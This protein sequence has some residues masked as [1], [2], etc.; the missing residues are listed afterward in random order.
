MSESF[1]NQIHLDNEKIIADEGVN[2]LWWPKGESGSWHG[3]HKDWETHRKEIFS[4]VLKF[5]VVVQAGGNMGLYPLMLGRRFKRV[6]TFEPYPLS[7]LCLA[8]NT[9][10][11]NIFKFNAALSDENGLVGISVNNSRNL[12]MNTIDAGS[13]K[14]IP[15]FKVDQ[16]ELDACDLLWLDIERHEHKAILGADETIK[17]FKPVVAAESYDRKGE[18]HMKSL[19]YD[20]VCMSVTDVVYVHKDKHK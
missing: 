19:G 10:F 12:G 5:D 4:R 13:T 6:Y 9:P 16:L 14:N 8:L 15:A 18:E 11:D 7:F 20:R 1:E 17:K 2:G 3:P